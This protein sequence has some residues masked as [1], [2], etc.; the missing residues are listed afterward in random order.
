MGIIVLLGI[1]ISVTWVIW[2]IVN[3]I[4]KII[5]TSKNK[6]NLSEMKT[7]LGMMRYFKMKK[8]QFS[9]GSNLI[10]DKCLAIDDNNKLICILEARNN[11]INE[12]VYKYEFLH[13][14]E[15]V[16]SGKSVIKTSLNDAFI[17][18]ELF[19]ETDAIVGGLTA[20]KTTSKNI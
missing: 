17:G 5:I 11:C 7:H 15:I 6:K 2:L 19:G 18:G 1:V 12:K 9:V 20:R 4:K 13:S 10:T 16:E 8:V 3:N 14:S